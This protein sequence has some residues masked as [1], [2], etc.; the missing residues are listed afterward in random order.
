MHLFRWMGAASLTA[1]LVLAVGCGRP[2]LPGQH[3]SGER[4]ETGTSP[5]ADSALPEQPYFEWG[6]ADAKVRVLAFFPIDEDHAELMELLQEMVG[7]YPEKLYV[8]YVDYRTP[9]G[10]AIFQRAGAAGRTLMINGENEVEIERD[11]GSYTV[12]FVQEM[13]RYW[14]AEDVRRAI[15][16][17]VARQ[18]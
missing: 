8:R 15:A 4:A 1:L 10:A 12:D 11:G 17:E 9:E 6:A 5:P 18:Y 14:T 7:Q 2:S 3:F 16:Q 13:G